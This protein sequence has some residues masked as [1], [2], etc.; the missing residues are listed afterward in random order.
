MADAISA[1]RF[2]AAPGW[3]CR[4]CDFNMICPAQDR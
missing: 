2:D 4:T 3:A 1:G